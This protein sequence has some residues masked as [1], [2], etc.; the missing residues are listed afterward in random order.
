MFVPALVA[1]AFN[2]YQRN[3][4][5]M[6]FIS[7]IT[8]FS[9]KSILFSIGYP[10]AVIV[11]CAI[12]ASSTG[13]GKL[14]YDKLND[15]LSIKGVITLLVIVIINC[16]VGSLGEELGWRGYLLPLLAESKGKPKATL[17]VSV[18]WA[19]Y[20]IPGLFLLAKVTGVGNPVLVALIQGCVAFLINFAF[21]YCF[22]LSK[23]LYPVLLLHTMWNYLNT[24][25]LGDIYV[26]TKGIIEGNIFYINGEGL[27]GLIIISI[28]SLWFLKQM[29]K[30]D[31]GIFSKEI[32]NPINN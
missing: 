15:L 27:L 1:I 31:D 12:T 9:L 30:K 13:F 6:I 21:S 23:S 25:V 17:W 29:L 4:A 20:H 2:I 10:I 22:F 7:L 11:V 5:K 28:T 19:L 32:V 8:K 16:F 26:N 3:S 18:V 14:N 24:K